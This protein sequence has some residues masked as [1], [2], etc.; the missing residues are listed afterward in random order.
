[1]KKV[2]KNQKVHDFLAQNER[3]WRFNLSHAP[4]YK[5]TTK[6]LKAL[7]ESHNV[8]HKNTKK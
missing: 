7:R 3:K 8:R 2:V 1:M 6:N 5:W 4:W